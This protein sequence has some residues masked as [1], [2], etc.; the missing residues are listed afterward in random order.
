M[1]SLPTFSALTLT[2]NPDGWGPSS[3]PEKYKDLPFSPFSK[4]VA[5][6]AEFD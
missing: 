3:L 2:A 1:T 6:E 5:I 4:W